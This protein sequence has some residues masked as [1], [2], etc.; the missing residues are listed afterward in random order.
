MKGDSLR[1]GATVVIL[2]LATALAGV[3][4]SGAAP[5]GKLEIFSWWTAGGEAQALNALY[6]VYRKH[7]P[8]VEIVNAVVAGGAGSNAQGTLQRR[9]LMNNPPDTFQVH[10]GQ[11][12]ISTWVQTFYMAPLTDVF[13]SEGWT[14]VMPGGILDIISSDQG[15]NSTTTP[16]L[17]IAGRT[18]LHWNSYNVDLWAVPVDIHRANVLWYNQKILSDAHLTPPGTFDEFFTAAAALKAK[19]IVPLVLGDS[20]GWEDGHVFE[21]VLIATLGPDGYAGLWNGRTSWTSSKVATALVTFKQMLSYVNAD[22]A[23][24]TWDGA[25]ED[26]ANAKGAMMIMGDWVDGWFKSKGFKGYGWAPAP[27]NDKVYDTL[28]DTFGLPKAAK[29]KDNVTAW[30]RIVGSR[31]GQEA[32]NPIKG[33]ICARTDCSPDLFGEYQQ[34][35]IARWKTDQIVPS[36]THGAAASQ[37]WATAYGNAIAGFVTSGNVMAT[38]KTLQQACVT[39]GMCR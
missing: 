32:F 4:A 24:L 19:G 37:Q 15:K 14:N 21:A 11:E 22:H 13:K 5:S 1:R 28:S 10:A 30:L 3:R 2:A 7:Y 29:N 8:G 36:V 20:E 31:E 38:Q 9:M 18:S 35:A 26:I 12:L 39:A 25:S 16:G 23:K 34:W 6:A 27:G 33:S 17:P